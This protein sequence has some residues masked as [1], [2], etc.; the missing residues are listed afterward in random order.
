MANSTSRKPSSGRLDAAR[1]E[2]SA[3][4]K[5]NPSL[6]IGQVRKIVPFQK[7]E[8]LERYLDLLRQAGLPE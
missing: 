1:A 6:T 7:E 4:L 2:V 5:I 8:D 3:F